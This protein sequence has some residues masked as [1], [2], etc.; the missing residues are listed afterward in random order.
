MIDQWLTYLQ[1]LAKVINDGLYY[2]EEGLWDDEGDLDDEPLDD[3]W[4]IDCQTNDNAHSD[5][6]W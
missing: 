4:T 3:S 5:Q 1:D 6:G 2:Y